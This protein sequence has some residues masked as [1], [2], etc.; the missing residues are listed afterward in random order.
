[1]LTFKKEQL[2]LLLIFS[3]ITVTPILALLFHFFPHVSL[4]LAGKDILIFLFLLILLIGTHNP[5]KRV[6]ISLL[7]FAPFIAILWLSFIF[8]DAAWAAKMGSFRQ[9]VYPILFLTMGAIFGLS[10]SMLEQSNQK[11]K[12]GLWILVGLGF[13]IYF[14]PASQLLWL[15]AYFNAKGVD[16]SEVDIPAQWLEPIWGG[17]PRMVSTF[18]D[19]V[20]WGHFLVFALFTFIPTKKSWG[21]WLLASLIVMCIA[22]SFCKGAWLQMAVMV[23]ILYVNVPKWLKLIGLAMIPL[24]VYIAAGFHD[25]IANHQMGL[26]NAIK[27]ITLFGYGLGNVGNVAIIFNE[28]FQPLI[29]DSYVGAVIG[30]LGFVGFSCWILGW[31]VLI[32]NVMKTNRVLAWLLIS[33]ILVSF[34]SENAFN[35]LS[36]LVICLYAGAE[37]ALPV[38]KNHRLAIIDPVG[39]KAGMDYFSQQLNKALIEQGFKSK[40]YS[41]FEDANDA[42]VVCSFRDDV[43]EGKWNKA[44]NFV[45]G[46]ATSFLKAWKSNENDLIFHSFKTT[47]KETIL[48]LKAKIFRFR[49]HLIVH[50]VQGFDKE[51]SMF[52]KKITFRYIADEI[53]CLNETSRN[54]LCEKLKLNIADIH[55]IKH[56]HFLEL[57]DDAINQKISRKKLNLDEQEFYYLFFGQIKPVKALDLLLKAFS[58]TSKGKLIIAGK[59]RDDDYTKYSN[60]ITELN[61]NHRVI[62]L[63]RYISNDEREL[64]FKA[65]NCIVIPYRKI[66][67]SGVLMMAM[68]YARPVIASDLPA[69][70]AIIKDGINGFLFETENTDQLTQKMNEVL[71]YERI[72]ELTQSAVD[73]LVNDYNWSIAAKV[74]HQYYQKQA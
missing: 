43:N 15:K 65:C 27:T 7:S 41:N 12:I 8:S 26:E 10:K 13:A 9:L 39:Q 45:K 29:F 50:D 72:N 74:F 68:S 49:L 20:N 19:P 62:E 60:L 61:L 25:G 47:L 40:L 28:L 21:D 67:Q 69:N 22:L 42:N 52:L 4:I 5:I 51:D 37:L 35:L 53:Y 66:Y 57:P 56:G 59:V 48:L 16:I 30:Q 38:F 73:T 46:N 36:V 31:L 3:V 70:A 18:F 6:P 58:K 55:L 32:I 54:I 44:L 63:V 17:I 2:W 11:L 14:T 24:V 1:M 34:Y 33:Q 23:G 64:L 71:G